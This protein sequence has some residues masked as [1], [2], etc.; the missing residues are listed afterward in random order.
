MKTEHFLDI[1]NQ[2]CYVYTT[3]ELRLEVLGGIRVDTLDRMRVTLKISKRDEQC[4]LSVRHNLDLYN[5]PQVE[6][7]IRRTAEKL[8]VGSIQVGKSIAGLTNKPTGLPWAISEHR[9]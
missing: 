5:D 1:S 9:H 2:F 8:K 3:E 7:L 6:K 4:T